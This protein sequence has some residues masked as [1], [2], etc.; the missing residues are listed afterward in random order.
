[1]KYLIFFPE[2]EKEIKDKRTKSTYID[3][4]T[5]TQPDDFV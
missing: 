4:H 1:M 5:Q 3:L 2:G